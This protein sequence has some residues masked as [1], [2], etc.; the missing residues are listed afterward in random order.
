MVH[1][2][3]G[4]WGHLFVITAFITALIATFGYFYTTYLSGTEQ[5][6]KND[7]ISWKRF[8]RINFFIHGIAVFGVIVCLY[9]IIS[10]HYYEYHYAW[11]H[12]SNELPWYY[13]ISCFWEGQEGSFLLWL[14]WQVI[15]GAILIKVNKTWEAPL[16]AVFCLVQAFLASMILGSVVPGIDLKIGSSPFILLKDFMGDI[17]VYQTNP[18]FV[19]ENGTGLNL[20]LQNYWMVIHPPTLFLGFAATL[21]PFSYCI[22]G[23]WLKKYKEWIRPALPWALF[24]ALI[25]GT[26]ILMGGYW[27]Y[28][29]LN[30]GGYW[31][32]DPVENAVYV[33]WLV[34]VAGIHT[35]ISYK[36][37]NSALKTSVILIITTFLLI[38][39]STYLTRSGVLGES[40]VHSFTDLGLKNQLFLYLAAFTII[41]IYLIVKS[42]KFIPSTQK[43]VSTYSREFWI[44][45]GVTTLCLAAF[46]VIVPT[47]I[48]FFNSI[49][50]DLGIESNMAPPAE[51]ALFYSN[52][53][54]WFAIVIAGLSGVG[55]FFWWKK[56]DK[57]KLWASLYTPLIISVLISTLIILAV[58]LLD[59]DSTIRTESNYVFQK[60]KYILLWT[61]AV[62]S[63]V[64]NGRVFLQLVR[65]NIKLSG[66]AVTHMGMALM[67][68]GIL[69]SSGYSRVISLNHSG[70]LFS[71]EADETFNTEN[72]LLWRGEPTPMQDYVLTYQGSRFEVLGYPGYVDTKDLFVFTDGLKALSLKDLEY[73]GKTYF[74]KGDT[75]EL[76]PENTY[77][78]VSYSK[79]DTDESFS[80]FP[81]IQSNETMGKVVS[82]DIKRFPTRD[83][84]THITS[85]L[86]EEK[87]EWSE[88]EEFK[89]S[90]GDTL[91]INDYVAILNGITKESEL[92]GIELGPQD[93]AVKA[94]F[95]IFGKDHNYDIYPRYIIKVVQNKAGQEEVLIGHLP[96]TLPELGLKLAFV[97]LDPETESF[98]FTQ[99][100]TQKDFIILKVVEKPFINLLWIGTIILVI[101]IAM[102]IFRRYGEFVKMRD[103]EVLEIN[104]L[105]TNKKEKEEVLTAE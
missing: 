24:A 42:W 89:A 43:E 76:H 100:T 77:F 65:S 54:I 18:D 59:F 44:F 87:R 69:F 61:L 17:P 3:I 10:N 53:Q 51:Q 71:K 97:G 27:A 48:P 70:L 8:S 57:E 25:L 62:F 2:G 90:V 103:K 74:S 99:S 21:V 11:S 60:I 23:L 9:S 56:M 1:E 88:P 19:P 40:S 14:F 26:G 15:L 79:K 55:Q 105:E 91:F 68:L 72:I 13:M 31:N 32:W 85:F 49:L 78:E 33:P 39:Y 46:Q 102:A 73:D 104:K 34:L 6:S 52:W 80:L 37:S 7:I 86:D 16:L 82:P 47:S 35:M 95:T 58:D 5:S 101:G 38:L 92:T 66:G 93:G 94:H 63:I 28:E 98:T 81:R 36:N 29:T 12:S 50:R 67:L 83:F 22:A 30:F 84:Y 20:L 45:I 96:E 64:A 41:S 75:V 4:N